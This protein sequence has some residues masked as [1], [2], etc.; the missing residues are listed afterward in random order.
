MG[1][2]NSKD[3]QELI[4]V[5]AWLYY[6]E[7]LT[8]EQIAE[9]LNL[10]RV[11]VTRLLQKARQEGV[12]EFRM[13]KP[14]PLHYNL[15]WQLQK[16][17]GLKEVII[18]KTCDT[19]A[20]TLD[21]V[22][23]ATAQYLAQIVFPECRLGIVGWS[24]SLSYMV[25]YLKPSVGVKPAVV[26]ELVG[27]FVGKANVYNVS[28]QVAQALET[29]IDIMPVPAVVSSEAARA[30]ILSEPAINRA[31]RHARQCDIAFVGIGHVGHDWTMVMRGHLSQEEADYIRS[32]GAVGDV[33]G[34]Y[35]DEYGRRVVTDLDERVI[36]ID[37]DDILHI[38]HVVAVA[39]GAHK[40][41]PILGA[42]RGGL[43]HCLITDTKTAQQVLESEHEETQQTLAEQQV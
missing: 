7:K 38:P 9:K 32:K 33:I 39:S 14:L 20:E 3:Q 25:P 15:S 30:A 36:S 13:T 1:A 16:R 31:L 41:K 35:Y 27:S 28:M 2:M 29:P 18:A 24:K 5:A 40:V 11:G 26:H 8:Q 12:V 34:R 6:D 43:C 42:L 21:A 17:Y 19:E 4:I 37:W 22:G 23:A 10:S